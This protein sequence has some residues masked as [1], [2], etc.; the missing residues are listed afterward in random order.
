MMI[1]NN[2]LL[3][4][5]TDERRATDAQATSAL[6]TALFSSLRGEVTGA[7]SEIA[8]SG[9]SDAVAS[10]AAAPTAVAIALLPFSPSPSK[11]EPP[12]DCA[13]MRRPIESL[14]PLANSD[15]AM[16]D[17]RAPTTVLSGTTQQDAVP[18]NFDANRS[19]ASDVESSAVIGSIA[20]KDAAETAHFA[21][22]LL[23]EGPS[24]AIFPARMPQEGLARGGFDLK[25]DRSS[26][27][28]TGDGTDD[29]ATATEAASALKETRVEDASS[30]LKDLAAKTTGHLSSAINSRTL[31]FGDQSVQHHTKPEFAPAALNDQLKT[32]SVADAASE[33]PEMS[34]ST[35]ATVD[36]TEVDLLAQLSSGETEARAPVTISRVRALLS[37]EWEDS[38]RKDEALCMGPNES[39][40]LGP[41]EN[42]AAKASRDETRDV[43]VENAPLR[44]VQTPLIAAARQTVRTRAL[45]IQLHPAELGTVRARLR[46]DS[47]GRIS[48]TLAVETES[49]RQALA[50]GLDE[51]RQ[52]LE[53][54]GLVTDRIDV[55]TDASPSST[56]A[57]SNPQE[58][59]HDDGRRS[60]L[61]AAS[62]VPPAGAL[63]DEVA[64]PSTP[65]KLISLRA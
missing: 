24:P 57:Q 31:S 45:D 34:D 65:D 44:Q 23:T 60:S 13:V 55:V 20:P 49:A 7:E 1:E 6:W 28:K 35:R 32:G 29:R 12:E 30:M 17:M 40:R 47:E 43:S 56:F 21:R 4:I 53:R 58:R 9:E 3:P 25:I 42:R 2:P 8:C 54:A 62:D 18:T 41:T 14:R 39:K 51:L 52:A 10:D 19:S 11:A 26:E 37:N 5:S 15:G 59:R 27:R 36:R 22:H 48:A 64:I 33:Q 61:V 46:R 63:A 16:L 38:R 50:S